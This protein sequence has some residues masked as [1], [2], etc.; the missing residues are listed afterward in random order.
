MSAQEMAARLCWGSVGTL[1]VAA[2]NSLQH[3]SMHPS[4][5]FLFCRL[6]GFLIARSLWFYL[7]SISILIIYHFLFKSQFNFPCGFM[8]NIRLFFLLP[9]SISGPFTCLSACS[10][11]PGPPVFSS[12]PFPVPLPT[13]TAVS[14]FF[15]IIELRGNRNVFLSLTI[16]MQCI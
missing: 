2:P 13:H 16:I 15:S 1:D 4:S 3:L 6:A 14:F 8:Q 9:P 10:P 5:P 7:P 12:G 11:L